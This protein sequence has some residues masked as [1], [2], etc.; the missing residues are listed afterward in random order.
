MGL[1]TTGVPNRSGVFARDVPPPT[2]IRGLGT[3]IAGIV[4]NFPWG[5]GAIGAGEIGTPGN[6]AEFLKLYAP[7]GMSRSSSAVLAAIAFAWPQLKVVRV[8]GTS[9]VKATVTVNKT[10]PTALIVLTA[11]YFG[12]AGNSIVAVTS[13]ATDGDAN[14]FDLTVSISGNNG[15]TTRTF[16]NLNVSGVGSDRLPSVGN[17]DPELDLTND[18]LLGTV[19]K[20]S[21]GVPIMQ[22]WSFAT[23]AD[24]TI[25]ATQ[26]TGT[27]GSGDQGIAKFESVKDVRHLFTDD[28]GNSLRAG[29]NAALK[30]HVDTQLDK[31]GYLSG[32]SGQSA[33]AAQ[34]DV[35][36]YVSTNL[37][38]ADPWFRI[39]DDAGTKTL[40]PPHIAAA[41]MAANLSPST[42]IMWRDPIALRFL[43]SI[44]ELEANRDVNAGTNTLA[45]IST[46]IPF[47]KGGFCFEVGK[48]TQNR[49]QPSKG[50]LVRTLM[51][52][53]IASSVV[54]SL[55]SNVGAPNVP[56]NQQDIINAIAEFLE[57]LLLNR[58]IDPNNSPFIMGYK[59]YDTQTVNSQ[60]DLDAGQFTV[61][62]DVKIGSAM[63]KLFLNVRYGET[64][65]IT[66]S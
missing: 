48:V 31:V 52:I 15:T 27:A 46:L 11:P 21:S 62:T 53:Y 58:D 45:G 26:Y 59:I 32:N 51:G 56:L 5:P 10:G 38:Y 20:S 19:T 42:S 12:A 1:F 63:E 43:S 16:R 47:S 14:H 54:D 39:Y 44:I 57:S 60:S 50:N 28:P 37:V 61:A 8:I 64:V 13:A 23:G 34:A 66:P 3:G 55:Q 29:V 65:T 2:A 24:G 49:S 35:A 22:S 18:P 17:A 25:G 4:G 30:T 9:A 36:S 33:S 41:C 6:P 7:A 40:L